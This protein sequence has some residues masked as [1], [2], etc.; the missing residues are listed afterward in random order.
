MEEL[1]RQYRKSMKPMLI[2]TFKVQIEKVQESELNKKV[3]EDKAWHDLRQQLRQ[4]NR[5]CNR[6]SN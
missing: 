5:H 2:P 1:F 6:I 4:E 3:T